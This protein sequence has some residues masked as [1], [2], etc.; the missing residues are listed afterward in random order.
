MRCPSL[1]IGDLVHIRHAPTL[2]G[3]VVGIHKG[4]VRI[5][6]FNDKRVLVLPIGIIR[7]VFYEPD[8]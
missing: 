4:Q 8:I 3:A 1:S 5:Y 2:M 7:K 6:F